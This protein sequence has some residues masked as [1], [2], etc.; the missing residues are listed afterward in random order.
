MTQ[1][2][3]WVFTYNEPLLQPD[4]WLSAATLQDV[5]K[6]TDPQYFVFQEEAA[7]T[8]QRKHYQGY[9][10]FKDLKRKTCLNRRCKGIHMEVSRG[11]PE[12]ASTYCKK[13]ESRVAG[14]WE[15]G[16]LPE[17]H[18]GERTDLTDAI[19]IVMAGG[20]TALAEQMPEMFVKYHR[21]LEA[22][23]AARKPP[24][25]TDPPL[26]QLHY[27][28]AGTGKS[29]SYHDTVD[30]DKECV[31]NAGSGYWFPGYHAAANPN[32][33]LED[34]DGAASKW[35]LAQTKC[36]LDRYTILVPYKGGFTW[37]AP[38]VITVTSNLHPAKWFNYQGRPDDW[39]AIKRR[40][41][42]ITVYKKGLQP[43]KI[44][45][46]RFEEVLENPAY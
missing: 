29:R 12:E 11:T 2:K 19:N 30:Y 35:T 3:Y 28:A 44:T 17:S 15:F 16:T 40:F 23:I 7:P 42:D 25:R 34:F 9:I 24:K 8:T 43:E 13:P 4:S 14:P 10:A 32:V 26:I 21:G 18:Q 39:D 22:L 36:V 5:L 6:D 38:K 45:P 31:I 37:W 46:E 27:G 20:M 33:L 41:T 1:S